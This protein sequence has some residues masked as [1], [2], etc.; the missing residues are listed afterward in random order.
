MSTFDDEHGLPSAPACPVC[1]YPG[2]MRGKGCDKRR[3]EKRHKDEIAA[4]RSEVERLKA[5]LKTVAERQRE[6]IAS[7]AEAHGWDEREVR[8]IRIT[9]LVTEGGE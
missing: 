2:C 3:R 5:A 8:S 7:A 4:L 1:G 6:R 9:P